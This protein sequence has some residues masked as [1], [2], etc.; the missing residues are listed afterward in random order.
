MVKIC[1][2]QLLKLD[3]LLEGLHD[4]NKP[5]KMSVYAGKTSF[6][7]SLKC[8][9]HF[10]ALKST[11]LGNQIMRNEQFLELQG[12]IQIII[13]PHIKLLIT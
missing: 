7:L 10:G 5:M 12:K 9:W 4:L 6:L 13:K 2:H 3:A 11:L 8:T 1:C